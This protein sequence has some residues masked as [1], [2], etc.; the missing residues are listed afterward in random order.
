MKVN[1]MY[2]E[3]GRSMVEIIGVIAIMTLIS[4]GAFALIRSGM[5][6]QKRS[7]IIDDVSKIVSGI[8]SLY[9][10]YDDLSTLDGDSA[11]AAMAVDKNGPNG[12]EYSV[13][14]KE[15][16]TN[17]YPKFT[18]TISKLSIKDCNVL[19]TKA[20]TGAESSTGTT[21]CSSNKKIEITYSK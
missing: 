9:A 11:L 14:K 15:Q 20:W 8:R 19:G 18:V 6:A 5:A 13:V 21:S 10:D 4:A 16:G 1:N 3:S 2:Q 12:V 17:W 7:I